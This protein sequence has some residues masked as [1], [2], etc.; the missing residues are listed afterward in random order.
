MSLKPIVNF[1]SGE[2]SPKLK[3][4]ADTVPYNTAAETLENVLVTK[5]GSAFRTP[6]T[7]YISQVKDSST[8]QKLIPFIFSTG[9]SYILEFGNL[10]MRVYQSNGSLV[11]ASKTITGATQ[12][13]PVVVTATSHGYSDGDYVDISEVVGMTEVNGKRFIVANKT[14][15]TFELTDEDGNDVD[16]TSYTAYSSAGIAE[17][18]YEITTPFTTSDLQNLKYTQQA[19]VMYIASS[20]KPLQKLSRLTASTFSIA[21]ITY[22]EVVYPPFLPINTTATTITPSATTGSGITLTASSSIFTSDHVGSYF[23][24]TTSGTTGYVEITGYSSGTS[25]TADVVVDLGGTSATDDWYEGAWSDRQGH[26]IDCKFHQN[27]LAILG[28]TNSPLTIWESVIE[29]YENFNNQVGASL[30][31]TDAYSFTLVSA[32]V[33]RILWG[34]PTNILN[35]GTAGGPFTVSASSATDIDQAVQQNE[36]GASDVDAV[37]I[38]PFVY[39]IERSGEIM[40]QFAYNFDFDTFITEDITYLSDHILDSGVK[41]MSVQRYPDSVIWCVLNDGTIATL[42][43]EIDQ[44]VKGWTRQTIS[45]TGAAVEALATIPNGS[46]DQVWVIVKRTIDGNTRRYVEYFETTEPTLQ[47]DEFYVHSGITYDGASA[48]VLTNLDHLE[49]ESVAILADGAVLP[50][51][52]VTSGSIT[53]DKAATKV[54]VGLPYTST[55]KTMD[56]ELASEIGTAQARIKAISKV[57]VR[58]LNTLGAKLGDGTTQDVIPFRTS[59]MNMDEPPSLFTGDKEV[60]FPSGYSYNKSVTIEQE[61]PLP[62]HVL[63]IYVKMQ[64]SQ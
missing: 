32:Q 52:T 49:G 62:M 3:G 23:K 54:Q 25:V 40:G 13:D 59:A 15:N 51:E 1:S 61:Q 8:T 45:G 11:E 17:K 57:F 53:I 44:K 29:E 7:R 6:G 55:I 60:L 42:T 16:G 50:N 31:E 38:G 64:V 28:T 4:R 20:D 5:Y 56:I 9:D 27:R 48:T 39:Y 33:D 26:P 10:Y 30:A 18:V 63:G 24:L 14:A 12:A 22:D 41:T 37:R 58:F 43:R 21:E 34:Y 36:N 35:I 47:E 19:D 46:S 2:A